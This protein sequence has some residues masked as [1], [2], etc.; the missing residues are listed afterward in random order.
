MTPVLV[1]LLLV[2][3]VGPPGARAGAQ[4]P[5]GTTS[6]T[7]PAV[8][9]VLGEVTSVDSASRRI[10]LQTDAGHEVII[11]TD[12]ETS[13]FR[14][15]PGARDLTGATSVKLVEIAVGDRLLARGTLADDRKTLA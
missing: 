2:L 11:V 9:R 15:Q 8:Q 3:E 10:T 5:E 12:A 4:A 1:A 6:K 14:A 7:L 13:A